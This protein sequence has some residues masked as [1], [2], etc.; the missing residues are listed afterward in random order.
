MDTLINVLTCMNIMMA[1]AWFTIS[2]SRLE[3]PIEAKD[4]QP[5]DPRD[6]FRDF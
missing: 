3:R 4:R 6:R 1:I 2:L 5:R